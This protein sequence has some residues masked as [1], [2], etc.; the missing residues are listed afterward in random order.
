[1]KLHTLYLAIL[2]FVIL[3]CTGQTTKGVKTIDAVSFSKKIQE[4]ENP[5]ILFQ[6]ENLLVLYKP[7]HM[8]VHPPED[9]IARKAVGRHTCIHWLLTPAMRGWSSTGRRT[10]RRSARCTG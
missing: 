8:Y 4:T 9:R 10:R 2:S 3:S 7:S 6:D 5:Q 1:M